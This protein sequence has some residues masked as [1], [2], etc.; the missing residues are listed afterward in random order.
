MEEKKT[1]PVQTTA[2]PLPAYGDTEPTRGSW[3]QRV[4]DSF[5]R[6]PNA[7]VTGGHS[8]GADGSGFDIETAAQNTADSP[9]RRQLKGRHLQM[10]AIGGSIGRQLALPLTN[11]GSLTLSRYRSVCRIRFS[12]G[13]WWPGVCPHRVYSHRYYALLHGS[14]PG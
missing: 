9:L 12:P 13:G 7:R 4:V 2:E 10:I 14:R 6:D 8:A 1:E 5:K 3:S 11:I